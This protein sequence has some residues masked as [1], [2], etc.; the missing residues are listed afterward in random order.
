VSPG[1]S[2]LFTIRV[3]PAELALTPAR[4]WMVISEDNKNG[5]AEAELLKLP[6]E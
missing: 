5:P 4:G 3:A 1:E 2:S 6:E